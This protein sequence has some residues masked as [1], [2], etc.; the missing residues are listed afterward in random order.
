MI[1]AIGVIFVTL[2][3]LM[4]EPLMRLQL[5]GWASWRWS[6]PSCP[7]APADFAAHMLR[8]MVLVAVAAR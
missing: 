7:K 3:L 5:P 2:P 8:H 1:S 6:G 4:I